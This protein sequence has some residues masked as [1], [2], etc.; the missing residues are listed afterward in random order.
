MANAIAQEN[1]DHAL[2]QAQAWKWNWPDHRGR[3]FTKSKPKGSSQPYSGPSKRTKL[4]RA[5]RKLRKSSR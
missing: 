5:A 3:W 2:H 1:Q 4:R